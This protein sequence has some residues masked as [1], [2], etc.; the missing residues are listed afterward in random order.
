VVPVRHARLR[1]S[2][3]P[4]ITVRRAIMG[5]E[6]IIPDRQQPHRDM[7]EREALPWLDSVYRFALSMTHDP[8]DAED[9]VQDTFLRAYCLWHDFLPGSDCR[10]WLFSICRNVFLRSRERRALTTEFTC[11]TDGER[12]ALAA[13]ATD[14]WRSGV[15]SADAFLTRVDLREAIERAL[16]RVPEPFRSALLLVDVEDQSYDVAAKM[17]RVP[18]GTLRSRL[19]RGRRLMQELLLA[20]ARD[21][22]VAGQIPA[23]ASR[24]V[25]AAS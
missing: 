23:S 5:A 3:F 13:S 10:R 21:L 1:V 9:V 15:D 20:Y 19:F 11:L 18:L 17:L 25:A 14:R 8:V 16:S 24:R 7:F 22:G 12:D 6:R 4:P 2:R